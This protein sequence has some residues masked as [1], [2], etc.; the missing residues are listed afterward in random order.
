MKAFSPALPSQWLLLVQ[1]KLATIVTKF[2]PLKFFLLLLPGNFS[3]KLALL[4]GSHQITFYMKTRLGINAV[5]YDPFPRA[6]F[7]EA[8]SWRIPHYY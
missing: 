1:F 8:M 4:S 7:K 2:I 3:T 6:V 5:S